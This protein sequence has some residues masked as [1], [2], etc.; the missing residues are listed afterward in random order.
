MTE[1]KWKSYIYKNC[2]GKRYDHAYIK[3]ILGGAMGNRDDAVKHYQKTENKWK[4]YLKDIKKKTTFSLAWPSA[5]VHAVNAGIPR[6]SNPIHTRSIVTLAA[7][8]LA[9]IQIKI[10]PSSDGE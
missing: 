4:I 7:I 6:I 3:D 9:V 2:F 5:Q 8:A 10:P 1:R